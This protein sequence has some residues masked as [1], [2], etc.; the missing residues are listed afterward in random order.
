MRFGIRAASI[1]GYPRGSRASARRNPAD[2]GQYPKRNELTQSLFAASM[3]FLLAGVS[4]RTVASKLLNSQVEC[5]LWSQEE[6]TLRMSPTWPHL[7]CVDSDGI[8][9]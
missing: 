7:V 2:K 5:D 9:S 8:I 1:L 3:I 4:T 6:N